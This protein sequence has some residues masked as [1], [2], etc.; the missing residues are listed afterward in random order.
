MNSLKNAL[1]RAVAMTLCLISAAYSQQPPDVVKSDASNNVAMGTGAL[2]SLDTSTPGNGQANTAAGT[3]AL[4]Q[5]TIGNWN[6]A[7]GWAALI[8]NT[9]SNANTAVG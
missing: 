5:N 9:T 3:L 8:S 7:I 2:Q 1:V 6:T 4:H